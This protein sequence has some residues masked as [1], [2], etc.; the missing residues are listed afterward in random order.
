MNELYNGFT[1]IGSKYSELQLHARCTIWLHNTYPEERRMWHHNDNNST[2]R[3]E[4]N[5]KRTLGVTKGW[6]D[7]EW[8]TPDGELV[9]IEFKVG[10]GVLTREQKEFMAETLRRRP[11]GTFFFV[12]KSFE[13]FTKLIKTKM[14][15]RER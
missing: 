14:D 4:G 10:N 15:G 11:V 2:S 5:K 12:E 7:I 6:W 3:R 1:E 13:T 9:F 8:I